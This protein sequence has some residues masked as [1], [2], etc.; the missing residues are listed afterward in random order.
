M[1]L[2][3]TKVWRWCDI[4]LLKWC[5]FL[6]G[7]VAGAYIADI[8]KGNVLWFLLAIVLFAIRPTIAYFKD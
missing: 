4:S 7:M 8:V 1:K 3:R 2:L 6:F 5:C